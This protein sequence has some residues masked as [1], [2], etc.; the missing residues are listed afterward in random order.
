MHITGVR[1][2]RRISYQEGVPPDNHDR[3]GRMTH[4]ITNLLPEVEYTVR[5]AVKTKNVDTLSA[6]E[7]KVWESPAGCEYIIL[8]LP[9]ESHQK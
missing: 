2:E 1:A 3:E 5:V 9:R 4:S 8:H 7:S 6:S